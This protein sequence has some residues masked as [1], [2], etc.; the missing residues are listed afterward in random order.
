MLYPHDTIEDVTKY[1]RKCIFC[2]SRLNI[3]LTGFPERWKDSNFKSKYSIRKK[4]FDFSFEHYSAL[5]NFKADGWVDAANNFLVFDKPLSSDYLSSEDAFV[6]AVKIF[7]DFWLHIRCYCPS[8]KCER[9]YQFNTNT[10]HIHNIGHP[11]DRKCLIPQVHLIGETFVAG[12]YFVMN[13]LKTLKTEI[14][15]T[16]NIDAQPIILDAIDFSNLP[17][18]RLLNKIKTIVAFS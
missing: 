18:D 13:N 17:A 2:H 14:Y 1:Q 4:R 5:G 16:E 7:N 8:R 11:P 9:K 3:S 6:S 12:H 10:F 15:S